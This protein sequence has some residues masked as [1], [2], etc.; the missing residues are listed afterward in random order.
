[1]AGRTWQIIDADPEQNE[2]TVAPISEIEMHQCGPENCRP[3]RKKSPGK[4][5]NLRR[6]IAEMTGSLEE[7]GI[8][9][10]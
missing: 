1:M 8:I 2:L 10:R 4:S 9:L 3:Y 5:V 6:S 7:R